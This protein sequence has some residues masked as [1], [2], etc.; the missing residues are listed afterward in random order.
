VDWD[1]YKALSDRPCVFSR[2]MLERS[3]ALLEEP[4]RGELARATESTPIDKPAD[5]KGGEQ[6][7]MFELSLDADTRRSIVAT[8]EGAKA[9]GKTTPDGRGLGGFVEAWTE[10][11]DWEG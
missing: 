8:I 5:H 7:D 2:W 10:Y 6:T 9:N 1:R 11:R 4:L 3:S